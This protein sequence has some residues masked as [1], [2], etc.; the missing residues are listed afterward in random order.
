MQSAALTKQQL[1]C[2]LPNFHLS[3]SL[4][5]SHFQASTHEKQKDRLRPLEVF[6]DGDALST[7]AG[8]FPSRCRRSSCSGWLR[9]ITAISGV[10]Q[11]PSRTA[12]RLVSSYG[13]CGSWEEPSDLFFPLPK[14]FTTFI[15]VWCTS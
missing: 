9:L 14:H 12:V 10:Y 2:F 5:L 15:V 6:S 11:T 13:K 1:F 3:I 8:H 4:L 7:E